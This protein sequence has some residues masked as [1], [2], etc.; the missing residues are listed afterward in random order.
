MGGM[1]R[2]EGLE[3]NWIL[4][5]PARP[6]ALVLTYMRPNHNEMAIRMAEYYI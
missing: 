3:D 1:E 4:P 5:L 2:L 6:S